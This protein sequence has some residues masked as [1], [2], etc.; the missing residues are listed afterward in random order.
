M[1]CLLFGCA[2]QRQGVVCDEIEYRL[3]SMSYSPDQRYY[4][5]EELKACREDE[6]K[7]KTASAEKRQSIY[8]RFKASDTTKIHTAADTSAAGTEPA[9]IS[10][11]EA[12]KDSSG[13]PTTSIYDRY[14]GTKTADSLAQN[15]A[16]ETAPDTSAS[17][18]SNFQ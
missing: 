2:G 15:P 18:V 3:N 8:D 7:K 4:M 10:V 14:D 16:Q 12:L 6:A 5:E 17:D 9:D 13:M 11:S 1:C